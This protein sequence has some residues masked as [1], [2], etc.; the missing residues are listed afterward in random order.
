MAT[1]QIYVDLWLTYKGVTKPLRRVRKSTIMEHSEFVR[2]KAPLENLWEDVRVDLDGAA[3]GPLFEIL[4]LIFQHGHRLYI[5]MPQYDFGKAIA[6]LQ[7]VQ[8]LKVQPAQPQVEKHVRWV[9]H[10]QKITPANMVSMHEAFVT[11]NPKLC[12]LMVQ[13]LS[14]GI[15]DKLYSEEE[16]DAFEAA[17]E[18][19]PDLSNAIITEC[20]NIKKERAEA[21]ARQKAREAAKARNVAYTQRRRQEQEAERRAEELYNSRVWEETHGV[22][23]ASG[24]TV[25]WVMNRGWNGD[26]A[27]IPIY[28]RS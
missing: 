13:Q 25:E 7:A 26:R 19:Q 14:H 24:D 18:T 5:Y 22:R 17:A 15:V 28:R 1:T 9:L 10:K 20:E 4:D 27:M 11:T 6:M 3:P 2:D 12:D 16:V 8:V 21:E 23:A